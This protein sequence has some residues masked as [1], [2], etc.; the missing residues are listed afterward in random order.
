MQPNHT[1]EP[2]DEFLHRM[3]W[4]DNS[5]QNRLEEYRLKSK[6]EC[7]NC[8][9]G[10]LPALAPLANPYVPFQQTDPPMYPP[11]TALVRGTL[12]SGLDL[13]FMGMV[14]KK[15]R[16]TTPLTELQTMAFA[17]Q[18]LALYLDTHRDDEEALEL[19]RTF[20]KMYAEETMKYEEKCGPLTHKSVQHG[21]YQWLN[22]PW[23]WEYA[24]N[25]EV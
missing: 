25:R 19:Y 12:Y 5:N 24:F 23:P 17:I 16:K 4:S 18:E 22:D 3:P 21:Q 7:T 11:R 10:T 6:K 15:E 8:M 9:M 2:S 1:F 13:P 20:Q 14:N